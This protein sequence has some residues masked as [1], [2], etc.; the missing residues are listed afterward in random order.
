[1][2]EAIDD[3]CQH[4]SGG[5]W[6]ASASVAVS[7]CA[8]D[9]V[10]KSGDSGGSLLGRESPHNPPEGGARALAWVCTGR[11]SP[12]RQRLGTRAV[13]VCVWPRGP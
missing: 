7:Y 9:A 10:E 11:E 6:G 1:M 3:F 13:G 2:P 5:F 4:L 12:R 8:D